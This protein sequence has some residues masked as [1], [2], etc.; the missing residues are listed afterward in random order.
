MEEKIVES[1]TLPS[2]FLKIE[3][4]SIYQRILK[5]CEEHLDSVIM[6]DAVSG[7]ELSVRTLLSRSKIIAA[8]LQALGC[9]QGRVVGIMCENRL[10]YLV[11][12]LAILGTGATAVCFNYLYSTGELEH[13]LSIT[14]P[15]IVFV[16]SHVSEQLRRIKPSCATF[17]FVIQLDSQPADSS[18]LS[19]NDI[20]KNPGKSELIVPEF[21]SDYPAIILFSSGSTGLPKGVMMSNGSLVFLTSYLSLS[22]LV[23]QSSKQILLSVIPLFHGY[24][25]LISLQAL[26]SGYT[27]IV[28]K[29]FN[30][31]L[32]LSSIER[33]KVTSLS[34]VPPL[35]NFFAKHPLVDNYDLSSLETVSCGAAPLS[36]SV[37]KAVKE[38]LKLKKF[39]T[40]YGMTETTM[41]CTSTVLND[42]YKAGTVGKL[43]FGMKGKVVDLE[44]GE[45]LG[46]NKEGELWFK[47]SL[48]MMGY[49]GNEKETNNT[50]DK[51]GWLHTG[52]VGY[53]DEDGD[54]FIVD[55]I[56]D[57][58]KYKGFQVA[59]AE[60][61]ALLLQHPA[62]ADAAVVGIPDEVAGEVPKG[63]VVKKGQITEKEILDYISEKVA[64]HMK[65]RGGITFVD[66]IPRNTNGKILRRVLRAS[67]KAKL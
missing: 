39:I 26:M 1:P 38:R 55:R 6:I 9:K 51:D 4:I 30:G 28:V 49:Y 18:S 5:G 63:F 33:Y 2:D 59:P 3:K 60:L 13:T 57:L 44:T 22:H 45:A 35:M 66:E 16:N 14:K 17:K 12:L 20:L 7:E 64:P 46:P 23:S 52:D 8:K 40:G 58:I 53:Y 41:V 27:M 29:K 31:D 36:A 25:I 37:E 65:I 48:L 15:Y 21:V 43:L 61:E 32:F 24:G 56:K 54:F 10:E 19:Y 50:I 34:L 11:I 67:V 42:Y 62:I 47:G